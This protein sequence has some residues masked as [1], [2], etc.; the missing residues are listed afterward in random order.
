MCNAV[1][2]MK[3]SKTEKLLYY[4]PEDK[5]PGSFYLRPLSAPKG[6]VWYTSSPIGIHQLQGTVGR[7][8]SEAG[9]S[10]VRTNHSLRATA[11]TRMYEAGLDEQLITEVTGHRSECVRDYKRTNEA[12][13]RHANSIINSSQSKVRCTEPV[14]QTHTTQSNGQSVSSGPYNLTI[15]INVNK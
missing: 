10:G 13:K 2:C 3:S 1:I 8:C 15:N 11:A 14:S 4:S 7:L 12:M 5:P 9:L 6:S